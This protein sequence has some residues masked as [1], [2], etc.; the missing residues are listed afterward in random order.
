MSRRL[1]AIAVGAIV[2]IA[3]L[4]GCSGGIP[5]DP[6]G[7]L[8]RVTGG[9][10]RVGVSHNP[11]WTQLSQTSDPSGSEV[12]LVRQYAEQ[13]G[14]ETEWT[15]G[16]EAPLVEALERG[17]LD[18]VIAGFHDDTPWTEMAAV[19]APYAEST[20]ADGKT[21]RHVM[22]APMGDN[23]FLVSVEHFLRNSEG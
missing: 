23:A 20:D 1:R 7:T 12:E 5:A 9:T 8:E 11:P 18:L 6:E 10:L 17:E 21:R 19:T 4:T 13:L 2:A 14:A 22:L 16:S 3:S 15:E